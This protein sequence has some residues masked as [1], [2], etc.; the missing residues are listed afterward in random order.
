MLRAAFDA[1][2]VCPRGRRLLV[3]EP[4]FMSAEARKEW[5][6]EAFETHGVAGISIQVL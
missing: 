4:L 1:L 2:E 6:A 5:L 3:T